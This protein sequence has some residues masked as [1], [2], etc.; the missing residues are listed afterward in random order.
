MK[1]INKS[2]D[3]ISYFLKDGS[4]KPVRFKLI[5]E[6]GENQVFKIQRVNYV[7]EEKIAGVLIKKFICQVQINNIIKI[8]EIRYNSDQLKWVLFKI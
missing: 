7:D 1:V 3:M 5:D 2:I 6:D 8:F 4:I